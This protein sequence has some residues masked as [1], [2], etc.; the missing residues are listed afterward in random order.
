MIVQEDGINQELARPRRRPRDCESPNMK[1]LDEGIKM[2]SGHILP[3]LRL[4]SAR[5]SR[6]QLSLDPTRLELPTSIQNYDQDDE[7]YYPMLRD[8]RSWES[9]KKEI[10]S[11]HPTS[12]FDDRLRPG[13]HLVPQVL[14]LNPTSRSSF[15]SAGTTVFTP[16][17]SRRTAAT[18]AKQAITRISQSFHGRTL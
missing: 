18:H 11:R 3:I 7:N 2:R 8:C 17:P 15:C 5:S 12:G 1:T 13:N 9:C 14:S 6:Y 16:R 10:N 4:E